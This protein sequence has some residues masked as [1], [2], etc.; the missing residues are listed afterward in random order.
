MLNI[1]ELIQKQGSL[2]SHARHCFQDLNDLKEMIK[3]ID[4]KEETGP[5]KK[6]K[7]KKST[8]LKHY[9]FLNV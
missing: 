1:L 5:I 3:K 6:N 4:Q 9:L 2:E 8:C 7:S